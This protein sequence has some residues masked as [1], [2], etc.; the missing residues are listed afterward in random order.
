[1]IPSQRQLPRARATSRRTIYD[2]ISIVMENRPSE[3]QRVLLQRRERRRY[4][5][6][7]A[8]GSPLYFFFLFLSFLLSYPLP[9]FLRVCSLF[10]RSLVVFLALV[11]SAPSFPNI[12]A[13]IDEESQPAGK[14]TSLL[15]KT[16]SGPGAECTARI[17]GRESARARARELGVVASGKS[18]GKE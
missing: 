11:A 12:F 13:C 9:L 1:M 7:L 4:S 2:I 15:N 8:L 5:T 3:S 16:L 18:V 6:R 10:T 17:N 14:Y